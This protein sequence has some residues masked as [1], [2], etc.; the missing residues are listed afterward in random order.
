MPVMLNGK[1]ELGRT[2]GEG[3][4]CKVKLARDSAGARYAI[5]VMRAGADWQEC[6]DTELGVLSQLQHPNIVSLVESGEG[7]KSHPKRGDK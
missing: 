7:V 6:V 2:L 3:V 1:Y 5:K 4:S